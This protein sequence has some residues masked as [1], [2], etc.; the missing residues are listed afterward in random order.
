MLCSRELP[1][2]AS[3]TSEMAVKSMN[4]GWLLGESVSSFEISLLASWEMPL[5]A[6]FVSSLRRSVQKRRYD[7]TNQLV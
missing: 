3:V 7:T 6:L 2:D 5:E 4:A 1:T